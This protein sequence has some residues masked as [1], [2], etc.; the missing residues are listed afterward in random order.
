MMIKDVWLFS[1]L[2]LLWSLWVLPCTCTEDHAHSPAEAVAEDKEGDCP[3]H[4]QEVPIIAIGGTCAM[5]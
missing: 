3:F 5:K 1:L 4:G 2:L